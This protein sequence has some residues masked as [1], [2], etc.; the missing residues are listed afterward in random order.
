MNSLQKLEQLTGDLPT[1][2]KLNDFKTT[3]SGSV[4]EYDIDGTALVFPMMYSDDVAMAR[5]FLSKGSVFGEHFHK[6][7]KGIV[8]CYKG[9][10]IM[11]MGEDEVTLAEGETYTIERGV[12]HD[13]IAVTD[14]WFMAISIPPD[15]YYPKV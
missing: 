4:V 13:A 15:E 12:A 3:R 6:N 1:V 8:V 2:P 9:V 10:V 5:V 14:T 11:K 7:S